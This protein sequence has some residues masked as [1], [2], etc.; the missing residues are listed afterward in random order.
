MRAVLGVCVAVCLSSSAALAQQPA[1]QGSL[2]AHLA[3]RWVLRGTIDNQQTTHDVDADLVL[4][5]GYV[6]LHEV[7]REK[8]ATG[9]PVYEAI[10]F[11]SMDSATGEYRCL[12]LDNT[13]NGGLSA[14]GIGRGTARGDSIP[15]IFKTGGGDTFHTTF[16]YSASED[17]WRW[18]MDAE[19][20]GR[21][22][23]FARV[24]LTRRRP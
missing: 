11:I 23:P 16:I 2:F 19:S 12:W 4:Q 22:Q 3:G 6:R 15:F 5:G 1:A 10:V 9:A 8:D 7:S 24:T 17:A 13:G 20:G 21:L 14:E 18:V